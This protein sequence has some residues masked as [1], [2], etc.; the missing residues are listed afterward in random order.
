MAGTLALL[1]LAAGAQPAWSQEPQCPSP[2]A[3]SDSDSAPEAGS[4]TKA[5]LNHRDPLVRDMARADLFYAEGRRDDAEAI[6]RRLAAAAPDKRQSARRAM[7]KLA[8]SASSRADFVSAERHVREATGAGALPEIKARGRRLGAQIA[9]RRSIVE[10]DA[11]LA[12]L[13][14]LIA[15]GRIGEAVGA[16]RQLLE[17]PCP[18]P[19]DYAARVRIRLA[20]AYRAGGDFTAGTSEAREALAAATTPRVR[21]RAQASIAEIEAAVRIAEARA[22]VQRAN[23]LSAAGDPAAAIALL[24]PLLAAQP[25]LPGE[26]ATTMRLRLANTYAQAN[27]FEAATAML[28]PVLAAPIAGGDAALDA[29]Q[30]D[31]AARIYLARAGHLQETRADRDAA[32]AYRQVL[33]WDRPASPE[34]VGSARLGLARSLGRVGDRKGALEQIALVRTPDASASL[35]ERAD[36]L[37]VSLDNG[38]PF[39]RL[40][41]YVQAGV[42]YDS[43]APTLVSAI[44]DEDDDIP[45]PPGRKFDDGHVRVD[46][47]LQYRTALGQGADYFDVVALGSRT[48][49]F[50]LPELDRT[51]LGVRAGPAFVLGSRSVLKLGG[52]FDIDWRDDRFRSSEPGAT[53][54]IE[55]ELSDTL[56]L[57]TTY[58]MAWHND[59]QDERD[60]LHHEVETQ[61]RAQLSD[62]DAFSLN[63]RVKREEGRLDR[64]ENWRFLAGT[65]LRHRWPASGTIEPFVEVGAEA[66]R[67]VYDG[68]ELDDTRRRDWKLNLEA[69]A[70]AD[71]ARQW[72]LRVHYN[73]FDIDS[74]QAARERIANHQAGLT[75]RYSWR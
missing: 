9:T 25:P 69:A 71:I 52:Q 11:A 37:L 12:A 8:R 49:Q 72:R 63:A 64:V 44:R 1:L 56:A 74:N 40:V 31:A 10:A 34:V 20:Q 19:V 14:P 35:I 30:Y 22:T 75:V 45:F 50:E 48:L 4:S 32:V 65:A 5:R 27:R 70:G 24:E 17:R 55:H 43:N 15:H 73:Y 18:L 42:A 66:E 68:R 6:Y 41:G 58:T 28:E 2:A 60:G 46:A 26:L 7:L 39:D 53:I 29:E 57:G 21:E 54:G 16:G 3:D 33:A 36:R 47:R 67:V 38:V 59:Y 61:L 13:D 51:R 23:A 62:A